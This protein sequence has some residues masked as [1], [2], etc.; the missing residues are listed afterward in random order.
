LGKVL[1]ARE[2]RKIIPSI[3]VKDITLAKGQGGVR[4][5]IVDTKAKNPLNLGEAKLS[6]KNVLF[7]VTPS[8]GATTCIYNALVDV[9][10]ITNSLNASFYETKIKQDFGRGIN[11]ESH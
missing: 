9:L 3:T 4:P 5:Q 7:N 2:V 11:L 8:P 6:G 10:A 1:F